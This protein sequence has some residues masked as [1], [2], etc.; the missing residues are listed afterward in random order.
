MNSLVTLGTKFTQSTDPVIEVIEEGFWWTWIIE[1]LQTYL[2]LLDSVQEEQSAAIGAA[3]SAMNI[4]SGV[5]QI[6]MGM[7][8]AQDAESLYASREFQDLAYQGYMLWADDTYQH[9]V[10]E[11]LHTICEIVTELISLGGDDLAADVISGLASV[12]TE[13]IFF[14]DNQQAFDYP[15]TEQGAIDLENFLR[16]RGIISGIA[17]DIGVPISQKANNKYVTIGFYL[18]YHICHV[19]NGAIF[20]YSTGH[21]DF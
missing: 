18:V 3:L 12:I 13:V 1:K 21:I 5:L 7:C 16:Y 15:V 17:S 8:L 4:L 19:V 14:R 6:I 20:A 2:D 10:T 9:G 11:I